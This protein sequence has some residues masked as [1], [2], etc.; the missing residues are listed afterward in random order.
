MQ[1]VMFY[2]IS[3]SFSFFSLSYLSLWSY[4]QKLED[5]CS[6]KPVRGEDKGTQWAVTIGRD[7][8]QLHGRRPWFPWLR[9]GC[10]WW[11]IWV[12]SPA[13]ML[14]PKEVTEDLGSFPGPMVTFPPEPGTVF[15]LQARLRGRMRTVEILLQKVPLEFSTCLQS[16]STMYSHGYL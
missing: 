13:Q 9:Q 3:F 7:N 11:G 2:Y 1:L 6:S 8:V 5:I 14:V 15:M 16:A 12:G 4:R 10:M